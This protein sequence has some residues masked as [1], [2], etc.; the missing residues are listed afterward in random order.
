[1]KSLR[2]LEALNGDIT[3]YEVEQEYL[4]ECNG[5]TPDT[6]VIGYESQQRS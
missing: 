5:K 4:K 6:S 1:M 3:C 2:S